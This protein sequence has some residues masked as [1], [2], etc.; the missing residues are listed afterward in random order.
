V[1]KPGNVFVNNGG[2]AGL[3]EAAV[4]AGAVA[5]RTPSAQAQPGVAGNATTAAQPVSGGQPQGG[6]A[7]VTVPPAVPPSG[8]SLQAAAAFYAVAARNQ[9]SPSQMEQ[10]HQTAQRAPSAPEAVSQ[11]QKAPGFERVQ[12]D[13]LKHAV[14]AARQMRLNVKTETA[15]T[16]I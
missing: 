13:E 16:K 1:Q 10:V 4:L 2:G 3:A 15:G 14:E 11:L 6:G 5:M 9:W 7:Q 8:D 12:E